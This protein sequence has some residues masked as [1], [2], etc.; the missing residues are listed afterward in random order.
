MESYCNNEVLM[1][2]W[3]GPTPNHKADTL[4][5]LLNWIPSDPSAFT[6]YNYLKFVGGEPY[7][8]LY[9]YVTTPIYIFERRITLIVSKF[10]AAVPS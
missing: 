2:G 3:M 4:D 10:A 7:F 5:T 9:N 1:D 8:I 6:G